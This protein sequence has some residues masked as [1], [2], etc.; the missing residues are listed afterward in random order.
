[1]EIGPVFRA[2]NSFTSRHLTEFTGLDLELEIRE[3]YHEV[4]DLLE[5]LMLFI[6]RGL[7]ERY[8]KETELIRGVYPVHPFKLP[9]KVPRL[10]FGDAIKL[11]REAGEEI[12]DYDDLTTPQEKKLGQL[13][14]EKVRD[15][16]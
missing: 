11:L 8:S 14:L 9:E 2:E 10:V 7:N 4:I 16:M 6:F 5:Q 3:N 15:S 13:V 1:M 12:G